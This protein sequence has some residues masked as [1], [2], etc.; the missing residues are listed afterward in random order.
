M[1]V[2]MRAAAFVPVDATMP[3]MTLKI[4]CIMLTEG[5]AALGIYSVNFD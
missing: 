4:Q 1:T 5:L 3:G 2:V